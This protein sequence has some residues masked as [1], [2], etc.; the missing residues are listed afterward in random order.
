MKEVSNEDLADILPGEVNNN[1]FQFIIPLRDGSAPYWRKSLKQ[2]YPSVIVGAQRRNSMVQVSIIFK[3]ICQPEY[4]PQDAQDS[5]GVKHVVYWKHTNEAGAQPI[6]V[7][8][9]VYDN[10]VLQVVG[11]IRKESLKFLFI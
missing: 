3:H 9:T 10:D 7:N 6:K 2:T 8:I 4:S 5:R 11:F 1:K